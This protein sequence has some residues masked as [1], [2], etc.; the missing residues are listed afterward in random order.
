MATVKYYLN[1]PFVKGTRDLRKDEV[2]IDLMFTI[3]RLKRFRIPTGERI[4]PKYWDKKEKQVK[5][6]Y[7]GHIEINSH[8]NLIKDR[9]LDL[10]RKDKALT[11]DALKVMVRGIV[12][13][14]SHTEQKKTVVQA[15]KQFIA[16]YEREKETGTVKR[17][18]GLLRKLEAFNPDLLPEQLDHNF[19]SSFKNWLYDNPNPLYGGYHLDYDSL[20][21]VY[22]VRPDVVDNKPVGLFD[23]VVFKYFVN[24]KTVC[25]WGEKRDYQFHKAYKEWEIIKRDYPP[26]SLTLDELQKLETI[27][28]PERHLDI[29]RD[30]LSLECRTGQRI[31]DLKRF[32]RSDIDGHRW[33]FTQKKG[34]RLNAKTISLPLVGYCAP[35]LL[36]LQK[37]NYE[38]P[39]I[40]EAKLNKHIKT[41]CQRAGI[42]HQMYIERYAGNRKVRI[43][44][45]KYEFISTHTGR[46]TFITI[47]LQF[48]K[49]H[50]VMQITGIRSYKTLKHYAG[51]AELSTIE[52]G[53]K[54]IEDNISIMRKAN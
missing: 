36:I 26:I 53:L 21:G 40:S 35:A 43:S 23:E 4:Q 17:Y 24:L 51:E 7:R 50:V 6:N 29:A 28:L 42:D 2:S 22:I 9:A 10:W 38:L 25:A 41:V 54:S 37:Y 30:Y 11:A 12:Q 48:M 16:Q 46:K 19:Y 34:S 33:T 15:V 39:R 49:P 44:G 18:K 31:S 1:H 20:A 13:G 32:T 5:S 47:A 45:P 27:H 8:L 52:A 14:D 3:D